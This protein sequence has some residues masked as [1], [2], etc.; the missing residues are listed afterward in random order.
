M[1]LSACNFQM[2]TD[3]LP[4]FRSEP[5]SVLLPTIIPTKTPTPYPPATATTAP[6]QTPS[7]TPCVESSGRLI[8]VDFNSPTLGQPIPAQVYLPPC[9][10]DA[11]PEGFPLLIMLHGQLADQT[12]WQ[13]IGLV[14][15]ADQLIT[16]GEIPRLVMVMSF[17]HDMWS[18]ARD[19]KYPQ[20][21]LDD[22]LPQVDE[23]FRVNSHPKF[24]ALGGYSRGANWAVRIGFTEPGLFG[25]IGAHSY[26]T[27]SGDTNLISSWVAALPEDEHPRLLI[28]VGE[29]D[30]FRQYTEAFEAELVLIN[31]PN[32][33]RLQPGGHDY[34][35]W[36][37]YVAD[38]LRWYAEGWKK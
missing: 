22:V 33:Y 21:L 2:I 9:Y 15:A 31:Y 1:L 13:K 19:S 24:R 28:D 30:I 37:T 35:Y 38:Y 26:P 14:S 4:V 11:P 6:T 16:D 7:P 18:E 34:A 25:A 12:T 3:D 23:E 29:D 36:E 27:F 17:E 32:E 20:A 8:S 5:T 10:A